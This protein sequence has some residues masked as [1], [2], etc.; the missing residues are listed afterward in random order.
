MA[1]LLKYFFYREIAG[2]LELN[3]SCS[4][5]LGIL[6]YGALNLKSEG[7]SGDVLGQGELPFGQIKI[8]L[9]IKLQSQPC[10][11]RTVTLSSGRTKVIYRP[12][13]SETRFEIG[14]GM[15]L[16][17]LILLNERFLTPHLTFI[18]GYKIC[19]TAYCSTGESKCNPQLRTPMNDCLVPIRCDNLSKSPQCVFRTGY[20]NGGLNDTIRYLVAEKANGDLEQWIKFVKRSLT[21][22]EFDSAL[23]GILVMIA[24]TLYL[25]DDYFNGFVHGD[26][27]PRNILYVQGRVSPKYLQYRIGQHFYNIPQIYGVIPKLWDFDKTYIN[28]LSPEFF[29]YLSPDEIV[30]P[31]RP[32]NED[33]SILL[34]KIAEDLP[35]ESG[36]RPIVRE[37]ILQ[38]QS[39][40]NREMAMIFLTDPFITGHFSIEM[41]ADQID[42]VFSYPSEVNVNNQV[43]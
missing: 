15:A 16:T 41:P 27:G 20:D 26:L 28:R 5:D 7:V 37:I 17:N 2:Q 22:Q 31:P 23:S 14:N 13:Y 34:T 35:V 33:L 8:P 32:F 9:V 38:G 18:F 30:R 25:L 11:Y 4:E 40:S 39:V 6:N 29:S 24:Y 3:L 19:P 1:S 12:Q 42:I 10:P 36:L 21:V 43:L